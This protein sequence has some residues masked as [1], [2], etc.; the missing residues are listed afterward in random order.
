MRA[1]ARGCTLDQCKR[2]THLPSVCADILIIHPALFHP[3]PVIPLR[4]HF[5]P[6]PLPFSKSTPLLGLS[7]HRFVKYND[8][9]RGFPQSTV[10]GC[11]GNKYVTTTHVINSVI[12]KSSKLTRARKVY[13]GV[14]GGVLP[15]SFWR[16]N[17]QGVKGG[18]ESAF[19]STTFSREVAMHYASVP[20]KPALVFEMVMGMIDRGAELGWISQVP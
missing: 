2:S 20:G 10:Y 4:A 15:E 7:H 11:K 16:P 19:M 13:R 18:I 5:Q 8:L 9:L 1:L 14:A 12:V 6:R 3:S 17:K